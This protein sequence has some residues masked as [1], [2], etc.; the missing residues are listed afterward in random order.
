MSDS[1]G[2][3]QLHLHFIRSTPEAVW[4]AI[5]NGERTRLYFHGLAVR[6]DFRPGSPI[7][8]FPDDSADAPEPVLAG[9]VLA[10]EV[11]R[12][13]VHTFQFS[14][15][16][17]PPSCVQYDIEAVGNVTRLTVVHDGFEGE[18][19]TYNTTLTGWPP[20]FSGLK[21]LL[22]TGEPL[23]IPFPEPGAA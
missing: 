17:D 6:S 10:A 7:R 2:L 21:T 20:I 12:R 8:Y 11:P 3:S 15:K 9:K 1:K 19:E 23:E 4:D 18:T 5:T 22:E 16:Q 13:L 14:D